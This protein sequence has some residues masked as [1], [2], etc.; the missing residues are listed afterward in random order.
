MPMSGALSELERAALVRLL[1]S[2]RPWDEVERAH[3]ERIVSFSH[4]HANPF[5]RAVA[6]GH[7]TG[8]AFVLEP[9]G[10]VLL[11]HHRRLDI[12]VQVGGHSDGERVAEDVA[13]REARE[14][15]G[16]PDLAFHEALRLADGAPRLLDVDVHG[17]PS[18][19]GEAAHD[20]LDLRFLLVTSS[21][22]LIV[23]DPKETKALEWVSLEQARLRCEAAMERSFARIERLLGSA[24][25][26]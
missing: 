16:L 7:L 17:I 25:V 4:A 11:T 8:S 20:H 24:H 26:A 18:R 2:H 19:G 13:L 1:A 23:A 14:E 10:R 9:S 21:P 22:E 3:L 5:D 12:W 6:E 15:S